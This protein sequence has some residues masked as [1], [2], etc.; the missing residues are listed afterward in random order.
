MTFLSLLQAKM[1]KA[2][3]ALEKATV[4]V[5]LVTVNPYT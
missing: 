1:E 3:K 2:A 5:L 4:S